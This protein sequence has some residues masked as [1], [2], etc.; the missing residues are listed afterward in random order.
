MKRLIFWLALA[1]SPLAAAQNSISGWD[2]LP[3]TVPAAGDL[4]LIVDVSETCTPAAGRCGTGGTSNRIT[5]ANLFGY[6]GAFAGNAATATALAANP[7]DCSAGQYATTIAAN[8]ALTCAQVNYSELTGT[9]PNAPT[10]TALAANG[11]NCS[12]GNYPLGVDAGGA[13]ESCTADDDAPDADAEVPDA[14]TVSAGTVTNS[15]VTLKA[16]TTPTADGRIEWDSTLEAIVVGDDGAATKTVYPGLRAGSSTDGGAATT[17]TALAANGAN[18]SAGNYPLGVDASGAVESCTAVP[19]ATGDVVGPASAT[20]NGIARYDGT[21]GKLLQDSP[22]TI[23]DTGAVVCVVSDAATNSVT[24]VDSITHSTSGTAAPGFGAAKVVTLEDAAGNAEGAAHDDVVW[25]DATNGS[26]D[27]DRIFYVKTAGAYTEAFRIRGTQMLIPSGAVGAPAIAFAADPDTGIYDGASG[28]MRFGSNNT[29]AFLL[30]GST[31][32]F[33]GPHEGNGTSAVRGFLAQSSTQI[34]S[35]TT[36]ATNS[37]YHY[38]NNGD[39]DGSTNTL[40]NNPTA[41]VNHQFAVVA[42]Q[43]VTISPSSGEELW[44]GTDQC[45]VSL[46]SNAKGSTVTVEAITGGSGGIWMVTSKTGT[47]TCNDA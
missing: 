33:V 38:H 18:C 8:G 32:T 23:A 1:L 43:T 5:T 21:T 3:S 19:S 16:G 12:A 17:A 37:N 46:T 15:D 2:P 9:I 31:V 10:A 27:S 26:E 29:Q 47:W 13:S 44:D 25:V 34:A 36:A 40:L 14:I 35:V 24:D 41:G 7:A 6:T 11:S 28:A 45:L 30:N 42:A 22:C 4:L 20:D 39:T